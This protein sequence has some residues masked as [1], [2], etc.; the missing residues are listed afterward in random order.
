MSGY[1][2]NTYVGMRYVPLFDGEWD[3]T[4]DYEP[5]TVV[6]IEGNSYTSKT[7]VPAGINPVGNP[8]Y[9]AE[10][11][12]YNAQIEAYRQEVLHYNDRIQA[13]ADAI[14]TLEAKEDADVSLLKTEIAKKETDVFSG[15]IV[16]IGDSY[17]QGYTSEGTV[18][19]WGEKIKKIYP[20]T[21]INAEGGIGF[22]NVGQNG[23]TFKG[24]IDEMEID[25]SVTLVLIGGCY[26]DSNSGGMTR[27]EVQSTFKSA[28][29]KF[30]NAKVYAVDMG[31]GVRLNAYGKLNTKL[32]LSEVSGTYQNCLF[33]D[34]TQ[35]LKSSYSENLA[36]DGVHPSE[37]GQEIIC[38]TILNYLNGN[39]N[40]M[41]LGRVSLTGT[42]Q[43][44]LTGTLGDLVF[45]NY[46]ES[47]FFRFYNSGVIRFTQSPVNNASWIAA[48]IC[49][50]KIPYDRGKCANNKY[51]SVPF[52]NALITKASTGK[53]E[54]ADVW[55]ETTDEPDVWSIRANILDDSKTGFYNGAIDGF[56]IFPTTVALPAYAF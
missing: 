35:F 10:T 3:A 53:F 20:N 40:I 47:V 7:F 14:T 19:S 5:L 25:N 9:W 55:M 38:S 11:G 52:S 18:E 34:V 30:P 54:P 46:G 50:I 42:F 21:V 56:T 33:I 6:S 4:K 23:H 29:S 31:I 17:L 51:L 41:S 43:D 12:N 24:L 22:H 13:N 37:K 44:G 45:E 8:E 32:C 28:F 1:P 36:S 16:C 15:K 39:S 2:Q 48:E 26:N 27:E 49:K